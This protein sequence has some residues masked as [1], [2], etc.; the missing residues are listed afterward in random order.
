[1]SIK[2]KSAIIAAIPAMLFS[3]NAGAFAQ[4]CA[5]KQN[6]ASTANQV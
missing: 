5:C 4:E 2:I 3:F 1:M 6:T